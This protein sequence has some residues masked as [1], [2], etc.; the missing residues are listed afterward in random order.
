[1]FL[2]A[3][4]RTRVPQEFTLI[5]YIRSL[6]EPTYT[7]LTG[8]AELLSIDATEEE[9]REKIDHLYKNYNVVTHQ[10]IQ[11]SSTRT[12]DDL[13]A[14][15]VEKNN[16]EIQKTQAQAYRECEQIRQKNNELLA[17]TY[18]PQ[19]VGP[20]I[21][22]L[23]EDEYQEKGS[24]ADK[25]G[26]TRRDQVT[27]QRMANEAIVVINAYH[28]LESMGAG[29]FYYHDGEVLHTIASEHDLGQHLHSTDEARLRFTY[30][31]HLCSLFLVYGNSPEEVIA[32]MRAPAELLTEI[33]EMVAAS[34][35][36]D[37]LKDTD[38]LPF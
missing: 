22:D 33:E 8:D 20:H 37:E 26:E 3:D 9:I 7:M 29:P 12:Y 32:D 36:I 21:H 24:R 25:P 11:I 19:D 18:Q 14:Q 27:L 34:Y 4:T 16:E 2:N 1:M 35:P 28:T 6:V 13:V 10:I 23:G 38:D 30:K 15:Q 17:I 31:D 5:S